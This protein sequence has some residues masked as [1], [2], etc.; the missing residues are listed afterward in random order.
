MAQPFA[1]GKSIVQ[2][3]QAF[4]GPKTPTPIHSLVSA[5]IYANPPSDG[6]KRDSAGSLGGFEERVTAF[7]SEDD[8]AQFYTVTFAAIDDP[9]PNS[10]ALYDRWHIVANVLLEAGAQEQTIYE[11]VLLW[12]VTGLLTQLDVDEGDVYAEENDIEH[13]LGTTKT[14]EKIERAKE[15]IFHRLSG[16]GLDRHRVEQ[17]DLRE[18]LIYLA[19]SKCLFDM[20]TRNNEYL[21]KARELREE[22]EGIWRSLKVGYQVSETA[23]IE[24]TDKENTI[25][26]M[27]IRI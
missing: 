8:A 27:R 9:D 22:F 20:A 6:Q 14:R 21:E 25:R 3:I 16:K 12:R 5:R 18:P 17:S 19:A 10:G 1:Y 13:M 15:T 11:E 7:T 26:T 2:P 24:P 4:I 23:A